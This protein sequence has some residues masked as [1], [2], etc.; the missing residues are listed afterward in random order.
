MKTVGKIFCILGGIL[1]LLAGLFTIGFAIFG[2][3][4]FVWVLISPDNLY[5]FME[6]I[7]VYL[8]DA[9]FS[10]D[11][12]LAI[13]AIIASAIYLAL[14]AVFELFAAVFNIIVGFIALG[15]P[16]KNKKGRFIAVIVL[17]I[18]TGQM[19]IWLGGIFGV[20]GVAKENKQLQ[21]PKQA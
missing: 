21:Q 1:A 19:L 18:L 10:E 20:I 11:V 6:N 7:I 17:G 9:G 2:V 3:V 12:I 15:A 16:K 13:E 14:L 8:Q 5:A 4:M